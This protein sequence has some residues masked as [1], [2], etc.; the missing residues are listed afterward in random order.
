MSLEELGDYGVIKSPVS[1]I[2]PTEEKE[3]IRQE[4]EKEKAK[5][6]DADI[7]QFK[8]TTQTSKPSQKKKL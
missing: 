3:R 1:I 2:D 8:D 5:T 6:K 7:G 4:F